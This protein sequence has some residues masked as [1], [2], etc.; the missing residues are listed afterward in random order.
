MEFMDFLQSGIGLVIVC[1]AVPAILLIIYVMA[2]N[3][4]DKLDRRQAEAERVFD[5]E[6]EE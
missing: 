3:H 4:K 5:L 6:E 2:Q 1:T